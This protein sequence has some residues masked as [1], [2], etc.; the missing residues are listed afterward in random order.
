MSSVRLGSTISGIL[1]KAISGG[2]FYHQEKKEEQK[3]GG[4]VLGCVCVFR[5]EDVLILYVEEIIGREFSHSL[6]G[7]INSRA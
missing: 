6:S 1:D 3:T 5:R 4:I 7:K 2:N